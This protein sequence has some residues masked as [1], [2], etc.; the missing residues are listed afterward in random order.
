M[1]IGLVS[2]LFLR[3]FPFPETLPDAAYGDPPKTP[4]RA[5]WDRLT[6]RLQS[7]PGAEHVGLVSCPPLGCYWGNFYDVEGRAPLAQG[8]SDPVTLYRPPRR[9]IS[10]QWASA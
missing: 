9:V 2:G 6:E 10:R 7:L 3:P 4:R 5:F 1:K 8:Q